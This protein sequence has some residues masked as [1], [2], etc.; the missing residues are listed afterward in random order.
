M[1]TGQRVQLNQPVLR[2]RPFHT[3]STWRVRC[4]VADVFRLRTK[5][6]T[7]FYW[8]HK[9]G[10]YRGYIHGVLEAA[11]AA[12][13]QTPSVEQKKRS[14]TDCPGAPLPRSGTHRSICMQYKPLRIWASEA[15]GA[16]LS[17]EV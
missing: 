3:N 2:R 15:S 16:S 5:N 10:R 9:S 6:L 14:G 8:L 1:A 7:W 11:W 13:R 17:S 4:K 12:I